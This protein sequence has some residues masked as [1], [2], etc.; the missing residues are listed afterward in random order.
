MKP[1][2]EN[3]ECRIATCKGCLCDFE[4]AID[5]Q[6]H[7]FFLATLRNEDFIV[8]HKKFGEH[9]IVRMVNEKG[10]MVVE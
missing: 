2:K 6:R 8:K 4:E 7:G 1:T 10:K 3:G 5:Y 9:I